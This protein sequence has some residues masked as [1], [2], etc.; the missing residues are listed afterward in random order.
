[1]ESPLISVIVPVYNSETYLKECIESILSQTYKNY[2]LIL[3]N[4]GSTDSSPVICESYAQKNENVFVVHKENG[5]IATA[6]KTG[7][8]R[9]SGQYISYVDSDDT[10]SPN[11]LEHMTSKI[12]KY[13]ADIV[14]CN[15]LFVAGGKETL[16]RNIV[17]KGLYDKELLTEYFY[18]FMLFGGRK[19]TPGIIPSL[20]NKIIRSDILKSALMDTD[21]SVSFG[22]D[23]LCS[24]PCLL[25]ADRVYVC[26]EAFYYY[27]RVETSV[28]HV[29]DKDLINKF[30]LLIEHLSCAFSKRGFDG[31][32]QLSCYAARFSLDVIRNELLYNRSISLN[33]R[34]KVVLKFI[35]NPT[36]ADCLKCVSYSVFRKS[37]YIKLFLV[38]NR[39][40][41]I[42]YIL[43]SVKN[44]LLKLWGKTYG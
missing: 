32:R 25:D 20:C 12:V 10:I 7:Y 8:A 30:I 5:G 22:E 41:F 27:R 17:P 21:D 43:F 19:G 39:M 31:K 34:K 23:A 40:I 3:V 18:P 35:D 9:A 16:M 2:E 13:D 24:F 37:N 36:I 15:M 11:M 33:K 38:K 6:R 4:D 44:F 29:Y 1:M 28:T 26:N 14:I 42:L